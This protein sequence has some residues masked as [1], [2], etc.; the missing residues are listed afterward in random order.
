MTPSVGTWCFTSSSTLST[1]Q[2]GEW[3]RRSSV[4][5]VGP[6]PSSVAVSERMSRLS[7]R[8]TAPELALRRCLHALGVRYRVDRRPLPTVR[9]RA[10]LVFRPSRVA[11]FVDGCFWHACPEHG[12]LPKANRQW[13]ETKLR[14]NVERDRRTDAALRE[15][16]WE[17]VRV[18]EHDA[19]EL[20]A[21]HIVDLVE[22]RR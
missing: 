18:W 11:V 14:L 12:V 13:W 17:V 9:S 7:R 15:A 16:G 1:E 20:A 4:P 21:A 6:V 5:A 3:F 19:P 8:D 22:S 2:N 10:D